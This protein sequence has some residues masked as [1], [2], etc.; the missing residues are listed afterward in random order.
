MQIIREE[1]Q[2]VLKETPAVDTAATKLGNTKVT[3]DPNTFAELIL[4]L[5]K[6]G[7]GKD[8]AAQ[9]AAIVIDAVEAEEAKD[10]NEKSIER[11]AGA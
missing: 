5:G 3:D 9:A 7:A 2:A 10:A 1:I 4:N 8:V 6:R 11:V